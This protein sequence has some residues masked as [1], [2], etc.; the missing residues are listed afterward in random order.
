MFSYRKFDVQ[1]S[2]EVDFNELRWPNRGEAT[3]GSS[4]GGN[5]EYA[6]L[7]GIGWGE[8][9]RVFD[10][11]SSLI[12]R[13]ENSADIDAESA[14]IEDDLYQTAENLLGL[15][16]GVASTVLCLSATGCVPFSSC[17]AGAFGGSHQEVFPLVAFFARRTTAAQILQT[18]AEAGVGLKNGLR[19]S[20]IAYAGDVRNFRAFAERLLRR[21]KPV[22]HQKQAN[23]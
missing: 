3:H 16:L 23:K 9:R 20:L 19:G 10:L 22:S 2:R 18:A 6:D 1:V 11:E 17:N 15:D 8:A 21:P 12:A 4:L 7:R 14:A 5:V 13:I